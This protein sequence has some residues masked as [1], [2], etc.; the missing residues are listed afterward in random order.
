[1]TEYIASQPKPV[2]TLLKRVRSTIRKAVPDADEMISYGIPA[3]K[4]HGRVLVYFAAF[5][6]HYS[7][8]PFSAALAKALKDQIGPYEYNSKGTIRFPLDRP[9]PVRLV[10]SIAKA[11]AKDV[12]SRL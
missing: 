9:V 10:A 11:R 6:A 3:Y 7:I 5:K 1:V 8:Y 4:L 2:Q 12:L